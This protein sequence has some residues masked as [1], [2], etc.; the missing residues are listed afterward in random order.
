MYILYVYWFLN[1]VTPSHHFRDIIKELDRHS[2][3]IVSIVGN[4]YFTCYL[5]SYIYKFKHNVLRRTCCNLIL[6]N[7]GSNTCYNFRSTNEFKIQSYRT[8]I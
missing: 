6:I 3:L 8:K 5:D 4:L 7:D 2:V 1:N